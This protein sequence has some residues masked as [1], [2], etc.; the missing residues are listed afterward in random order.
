MPFGVETK[1]N[2]KVSQ[3]IKL[4]IKENKIELPLFIINGKKEGPTLVVTAGIH[5]TEYASIEAALRLGRTL[6][7]NKIC[8]KIIILPIVNMP[9]FR[10]RTI[11]IGPYD[12]KNLNR[13]FP[14]K[15]KGS[16]SEVLAFHV[17]HEVISKA[18]YYIDLHGGDMIEAL[19]PF[20]IYA[21]SPNSKVNITSL[22]LAK[23]FGIE[24]VVDSEIPGTTLYSATQAG[25]PAII[26][27]AGGQ[28]IWDENTVNIH[29]TGVRRVMGY[30]G[31]I[32]EK[33]I[34][35]PVKIF[36]FPWLFSDFDGIFYPQV[37]IGNKV[38]VN[39]KLGSVCDYFGRE[40]QS[41][42]SPA[43][44]TILF[45]VTSLVIN[46][47]DPLLAIGERPWR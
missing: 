19:V 6:D 47:G 1:S 28:G 36:S 25:I 45:L 22:S 34:P 37:G 17:F 2:E 3:L 43:E 39:Q 21:P 26:S 12:R 32:N 5:G 29:V 7:P 24:L 11:Y 41:V 8:G 20:S 15:Q 14:G 35:C 31:M 40:L 46:K 10:E 9:S 13:V 4:S 23:I 16:S 42:F 18:D 30:L 33:P 38:S 27:E 44:G